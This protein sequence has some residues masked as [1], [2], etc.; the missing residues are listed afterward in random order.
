MG[1]L[2]DKEHEAFYLRQAQEP[3][4][5]RLAE[6]KETNITDFNKT[7]CK[8]SRN[9]T[10]P[11]Q[12]SLLKS[13]ADLDEQKRCLTNMG[14]FSNERRSSIKHQSDTYLP[15]FSEHRR[16]QA[17][18]HRKEVKIA[19]VN[20]MN[21]ERILKGAPLERSCPREAFSETHYLKPE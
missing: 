4:L 9:L 3:Y 21:Y 11:P 1:A 20:L 17:P 18:S 8:P 14:N 10:N 16:S 12:C 6:S 7:D 5:T 13:K 19:Q 15:P 2:A